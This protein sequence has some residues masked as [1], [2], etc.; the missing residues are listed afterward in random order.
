MNRIKKLVVFNIVVL[1]LVTFTSC[2]KDDD[3]IPFII[4]NV[5]PEDMIDNVALQKFEKYVEEKT[6]G[7]VDVQIYANSLLG[8]ERELTE[9]VELGTIQMCMPTA[10]VMAMYSDKFNLLELPFLFDDYDSAYA[11]YDGELGSI[12]TGY[13]EEQGLTSLG[14][15]CMGTRSISNSV[16]PIR[17][18]SD[19]KGLKI[20][21]IE[22]DMFMTMFSLLGAN[23]TPMSYSEI[24]TGLQ[25]S[26]IVGQDNP[27]YL[28]YINK[29]YEHQQY[30]TLT[31]HVYLC[32]PVIVQMEYFEK[33]DPEIR[34]VIE[35]GIDIAVKE[36]RESFEKQEDE[37]TSDMAKAGVEIIE[38][39]KEERDQFVK[40]VEPIYEKFSKIVGDDVMKLARSY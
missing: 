25:Q 24:Y 37:S 35:D 39:T 32:V 13:M 38:L 34:Q 30:Y 29:Y 19:M 15:V 5:N 14:Y 31:R 4:A 7:K 16:R 10:S 8:G 23:P 11:A 21:S 40:A 33:L 3:T 20:R 1:I 27:P 26:T 22:S 18:P 28:T 6:D 12:F 17:T 9:S 2:G 36:M